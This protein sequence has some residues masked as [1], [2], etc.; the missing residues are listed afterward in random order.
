MKYASIIPATVKLNVRN[1]YE[2]WLDFDKHKGTF[3]GLDLFLAH[4]SVVEGQSLLF[5]YHGGFDFIVSIMDVDGSETVYP[6]IIH[7]LQRTSLRDGIPLI[8]IVIYVIDF[9]KFLNN[10]EVS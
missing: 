7:H 1:G 3:I 4:F 10:F 9:L 8:Y 2:I 5:D 6:A